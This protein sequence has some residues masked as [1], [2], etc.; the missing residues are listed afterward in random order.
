MYASHAGGD[1]TGLDGVDSVAAEALKGTDARTAQ[2]P[3]IT[4]LP[5][6]MWPPLDCAT[7]VARPLTRSEIGFP[8]AAAQTTHDNPRAL[9]GFPSN[10]PV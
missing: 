8:D 2:A 3:S 10:Q 5:Q 4:N 6:A 1:A 9:E 7:K